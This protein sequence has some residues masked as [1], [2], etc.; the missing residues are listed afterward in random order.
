MQ[1][2]LTLLGPRSLGS[3]RFLLEHFSTYKINKNKL[4]NMGRLHVFKLKNT[5]IKYYIVKL[6]CFKIIL[7]LSDSEHF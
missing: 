5:C 3:L 4:I 1:E 7:Y 6:N 2:R